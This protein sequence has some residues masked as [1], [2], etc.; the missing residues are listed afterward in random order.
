M[1]SKAHTPKYN[2]IKFQPPSPLIPTIRPKHNGRNTKKGGHRKLADESDYKP[3]RI[4]FYSESLKQT[5]DDKKSSSQQ[6]A[7]GEAIIQQVLPE[8]QA[9]WEQTLSVIPLSNLV[10]PEDVCFNL[11]DVPEVWSKSTAGLPNTDLIIFVS[12]F[13]KIGA[14]ELCS[15]DAALSTLAV[16]SPCAIDPDND[17]PVVG[18][19]NVC[20]NTIAMDSSG[21]VNQDSINSLVDV[22]SHELVHVLGLNSE[23]F[24]YF[25]N[26]KTGHP[27]TKR[28]KN[29]LGKDVGFEIVDDVP[30]VGEQSNR[31]L[32][33]PCENTVRY[34]EEKYIYGEKVES[35]GFYEVVLPTVAQVA[36]NQFNCPSLEGVR[37]ENQ[38]TS[39]DCMGSHF[40]ERTWFTEFMSAVYDKEAAYFSPL[41]LAFLEGK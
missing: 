29:F 35:R 7:R 20:L 36:R 27:L 31:S 22:M 10:I 11:Y 33:M 26:S 21:K 15:Q 28:K 9:I 16:S 40:D 18:F 13:N 1:G 23:L 34:M 19:A 37:L 41:T 25:R 38:P 14:T 3:I 12:A 39:E 8:V 17:R 5:I 30:C 2:R 24:K 4:K 6:K 32:E